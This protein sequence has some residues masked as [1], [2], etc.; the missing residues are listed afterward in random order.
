MTPGLGLDSLPQ[1][2]RSELGPRP[3]LTRQPPS[4]M[5]CDANWPLYVFDCN[6]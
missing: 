4:R 1:F 3:T 6:L 5:T 2:Q